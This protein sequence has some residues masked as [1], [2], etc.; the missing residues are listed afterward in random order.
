MVCPFCLHK[1]TQVANSRPTKRLNMTW[2]RRHCQ[3]CGHDFSTK[4]IAD[5]ESILR[6]SSDAKTTTPFSHA[7]LL[8]SLMRVCDHLTEHGET[9]FWICDTIEQK[10]IHAAAGTGGVVSTN[11]ILQTTLQTL[12]SFDAPA[13]VK[14]LSYHSANLD[15][16][17]LKKQL[18]GSH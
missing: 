18:R 12:K 16:R 7:K 17:T 15:M 11:T 14:Y 5:T 1:K 8:T 3:N 6:V 2:R 10:L 13:Y 4:E 9:A